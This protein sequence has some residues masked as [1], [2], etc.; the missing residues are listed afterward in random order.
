MANGDISGEEWLELY[1]YLLAEL[2][3]RG[4]GEVR[5][6]IEIAASAP[7][8][9]ESTPE[10]EA[11]ISKLVR[12]EVGKAIIRRRSPEEVF[13]AAMGVLRSRLVELPRLAITLGKH[14]GI[15][16]DHIEF[17]VDY[18]QRYALVESEPVQL[19]QLIVS[20]EES[21]SLRTP[22]LALG[23]LTRKIGG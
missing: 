21:A 15:A 22:L 9:E 8:V 12:G 11:R 3:K 10:D 5:A 17:R 1:R 13:G 4:F 18:E 20:E 23:A 19:N 2:D 7:V 6:E 16:A 14:L